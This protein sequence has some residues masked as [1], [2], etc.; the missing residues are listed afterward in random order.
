MLE[1]TWCPKLD[2]QVTRQYGCQL[3]VGH[4]GECNTNRNIRFAGV[5]SDALCAAQV[6]YGEWAMWRKWS[7]I[8]PARHSEA[9]FDSLDLPE[10]IFNS[11]ADW[12]YEEPT[13]ALIL[14][15]GVGSGKTWVACAAARYFH[16][17]TSAPTVKIASAVDMFRRLRPEGGE[18]VDDYIGPRLLVLDDLGIEKPSEW[19]EETLFAIVDGRWRDCKPTIVTTNL[20]P[21]ELK[22]HLGTRVYDRLRDQAIAVTLPGAS[23]RTSAA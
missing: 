8:C 14:M 11:L 6:A 9:D 19:T 3:L 18:T 2:E 12:T 22:T 1:P 5:D 20:L 15:G 23:R 13:S 17:V 10:E 21:S 16:F 4:A 7:K